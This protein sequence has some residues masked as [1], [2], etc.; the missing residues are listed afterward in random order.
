VNGSLPNSLVQSAT[1]VAAQRD[2]P[3]YRE[4][5]TADQHDQPLPE[6]EDGD[7]QAL[8]EDRFA[9]APRRETFAEQPS[10]EQCN[11]CEN[12]EDDGSNESGARPP[13][14]IR[15]A[16]RDH[17]LGQCRCH[18]FPCSASTACFESVPTERSSTTV[19]FRLFSV[20]VEMAPDE[21][22]RD[23]DAPP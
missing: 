2:H 13:W 17:R 1:I 15:R 23:D 22:R 20:R 12:E 5:Q 3:R 6:G 4:I 7:E 9:C 8:R 16:R 18:D 11:D 10:R 21:H 14:T 19:R